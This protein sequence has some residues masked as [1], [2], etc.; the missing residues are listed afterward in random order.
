MIDLKP[1]ACHYARRFA[2]LA[3]LASTVLAAPAIACQNPSF[4]MPK[5]ASDPAANARPMPA[6][7][8]IVVPL[9]ADYT[10]V[11]NES[12]GSIVGMWHAVL[13]IGNA[14]GLVFDEVLEQFHSDGTELLISQ[15]LPPALGNVCIGVWKRVGSQTF[16]LRHMTWNW[17]P[18]DGGFGVPGTFAGHFELTMTLRLDARGRSFSGTWSAQ[19][20]D[21]NGEHIP[22]LD[23]EG[24]VNGVRL[25]VD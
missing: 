7:D 24:V 21:V 25:T 19:N 1:A 8:E 12:H 18:P 5:A 22:E 13:R 3:I 14:S 17:S 9:M 20:F 15:G 6:R 10:L 2:A 16:K 4:A 23:A 11:S